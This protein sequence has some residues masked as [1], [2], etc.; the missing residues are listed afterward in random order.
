[1]IAASVISMCATTVGDTGKNTYVI[2]LEHFLCAWFTVEFIIR[3]IFCPNK[4][5]FVKGIMNWIDLLS[6]VPFYGKILF[7]E[8]SPLGFLRFFRLFRIFHAYR[9]FTFTSGLQIIVK[10]LVASSR[11]L[12]LLVI[13]LLLP[14][15]I[16]ASILYEIE[17]DYTG[18]KHFKNIPESIWWA[19][20]TMTTVGYGDM[21]PLSVPGRIVGGICALCGVLI[22]AL[23]VTVIGNNFNTYYA[24]AQARLSLPKKKRRLIMANDMKQLAFIQSHSVSSTGT[25]ADGMNSYAEHLTEADEQITKNYRRYHRR[26]R[27]TLFAGGDVYIGTTK[28]KSEYHEQPESGESATVQESATS[29][30]RNFKLVNSVHESEE[31]IEEETKRKIMFAQRD[32]AYDNRKSSGCYRKD[33]ASPSSR[34]SAELRNAEGE[35]VSSKLRSGKN[36]RSR[37]TPVELQQPEENLK[38]ALPTRNM[39]AL[40]LPVITT[41]LPNTQSSELDSAVE[42][43]HRQ[44]AFEGE[45]AKNENGVINGRHKKYDQHFMNG[46]ITSRTISK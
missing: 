7:K 32:A 1:M 19:I 34:S 8:N 31:Y 39:A 12:F 29:L 30:P 46:K 37:I 45:N 23:P 36:F 24:H 20:I 26:S 16:F 42:P 13:I 40:R 2:W 17:N 28:S 41:H 3:L 35:S 27:N 15:A 11:E 9:L 21:T 14:V 6:L 43:S 44:P 5:L 33:S 18:Q 25:N 4:L 38:N 10:S 22:V